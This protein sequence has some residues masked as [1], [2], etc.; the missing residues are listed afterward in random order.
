M[1][2]PKN[3]LKIADAPNRLAPPKT[4]QALQIVTSNRHPW[5]GRHVIVIH[6][7]YRS[8]PGVVKNVLYGQP[9]ASGYKVEVQLTGYKVEVQLTGYDP[10]APYSMLLL[11][12]DDVV[13][14]L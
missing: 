7:S 9:T 6:G 11:D 4:T 12:Y 8:K 3:C 13:D 14:E 5:C 2:A 1:Q 10:S